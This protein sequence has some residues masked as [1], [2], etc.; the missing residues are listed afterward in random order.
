[1]ITKLNIPMKVLR[2]HYIA[3]DSLRVPVVCKSEFAR[4]TNDVEIAFVA[5]NV[6]AKQI[7]NEMILILN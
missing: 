3:P 2:Q 1:M 5:I 7:A 4:I 6:R